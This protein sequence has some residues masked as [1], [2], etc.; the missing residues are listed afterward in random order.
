MLKVSDQNTESCIYLAG[1]LP[2]FIFFFLQSSM[3]N[4]ILSLKKAIPLMLTVLILLFKIFILDKFTFREWLFGSALL[5]ITSVVFI[6]QETFNYLFWLYVFLQVK[7]LR[8]VG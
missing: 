4:Q 1:F 7:I 2:M 6:E 5:L 8:L 3:F